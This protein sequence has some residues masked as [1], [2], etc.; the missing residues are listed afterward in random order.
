[1]YSDCLHYSDG[2][3][4]AFSGVFSDWKSLD[5]ADNLMLTVEDAHQPDQGLSNKIFVLK[6]QLIL[7]QGLGLIC[8]TPYLCCQRLHRHIG[9]LWKFH[10]SYGFCKKYYVNE[11]LCLVST[12]L[13]MSELSYLWVQG[14]L[15]WWNGSKV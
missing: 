5:F 2:G 8:K 10:T 15:S 12:R 7:V 14:N 11:P 9:L 6:M 13:E 3:L 4:I 1:M